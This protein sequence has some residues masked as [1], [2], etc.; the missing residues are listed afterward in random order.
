MT[1]HESGPNPRP[2]P[3]AESTVTELRDYYFNYRPAS[4]WRDVLDTN[5]ASVFTASMAFLELLDAGN[6]KRAKH[7]PTSQ[8]ITVGSVGGMSRYTTGFVY[9]ASKAGVHHLMKN[10][11]ATLV[12]FDIRTNVVAPGCKLYHTEDRQH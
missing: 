1:A 8:I 6:K 5:L 2:V 12:P 3:D 11:G 9:N 4:V 7:L 10:L